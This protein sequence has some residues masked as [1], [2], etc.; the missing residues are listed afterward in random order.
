MD[1]FA[2]MQTFVTVVEAGSITAAAERL[3]VAKSAVSRRLA[4]L[5]H[6]LGVQLLKRTTR[7][8]D[9]TDTGR[10]YFL[11]CQTILE[12]VRETEIAVSTEHGALH[13]PIRVSMPLTFGLLHLR[14]AI[15]D[16][17]HQ[18]PGVSFDLDL[19]DRQVDLL[20]EGFDLAIRIARLADSSL[21][22]RRLAPV[23]RVVCASPDYW[24]RRSRPKNPD[25]LADHDCLYYSLTNEP[26]TWRYRSA[27]GTDGSV[28]VPAVMRANN[29][30]VLR[31]LA[32]AGHGVAILPTFIVYRAIEAGRLEPVLP[33]VEWTPLGAYAVYPQSRHLSSRIR[34]FVDF[35]AQRFGDRPY[36]DDCL[37]P[38]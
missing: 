31:D 16:F 2:N 32:I 7:R 19:G 36:W 29:G 35:L 6:H 17:L 30:D 4:E 34:S 26:G 14:A 8:L 24:S 28:K 20:G 15:S 21:I 23:R 1:R 18:N 27:G 11:R 13:G 9:L 37:G 38:R 25:D 12:D 3:E 33:D 5:E 10:S 22:A